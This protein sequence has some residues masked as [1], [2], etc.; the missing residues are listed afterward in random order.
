LLP[1]SFNSKFIAPAY[2]QLLPPGAAPTIDIEGFLESLARRMGMVGKGATPDMRRAAFHFVRWWREEGGLISASSALQVADPSFQGAV[3]AITH[4]WGFDLEWQ[5]RADEIAG[6]D[7]QAL[8]QDKMEACIDQH[9]AE[10]ERQE[11]SENNVSATQR[12][13]QLAMEEQLQRKLKYEQKYA[14]R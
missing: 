7:P 8:I 13:K 12:K 10:M 1:V 9:L 2:L 14:K 3:T 6:K 4:G 11:E 5:L